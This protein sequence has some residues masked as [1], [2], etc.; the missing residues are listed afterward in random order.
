MQRVQALMRRGAPLTTAC[1]AWMFGCQVLLVL[2]FACETLLP[3]PRRFPQIS[4]TL[5]T[6]PPR[7]ELEPL[8]LSV[9]AVGFN[10]A[11]ALRLASDVDCK[12][13]GRLVSRPA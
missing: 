10:P 9:A 5:A 3:T 11:W 7:A 2:L 12:S 6:M 13:G 4:Q 8:L 1:T